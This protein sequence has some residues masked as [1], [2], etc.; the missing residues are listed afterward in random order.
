MDS[1]T[2]SLGVD[3]GGGSKAMGMAIAMWRIEPDPVVPGRL[4]LTRDEDGRVGFVSSDGGRSWERST[5]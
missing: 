1:S 3:G 4:L 5:G 2:R